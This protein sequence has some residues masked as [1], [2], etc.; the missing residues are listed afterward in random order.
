MPQTTKLFRIFGIQIQIHYSWWFIF[1]LLTWSLSSAFFPSFFPDY[2][3]K[4]YWFMGA[5]SSLLLFVSVLFHELS[6]SLVARLRK[7]K[8]E[9]IT[10]FF[11][12]GVAGI[13]TEDIK[14]MSEFLMA[15]SGP[16]FSLVL[17]G[18]FY[19]IYL[20]NFNGVSTA[21]TF[22]LAQ[23]NLILALFN[24]VPGF[25]LDG[26]RAFRAI[27]YAYYKD[28][29]KA[30]RIASTGGKI[31]GAFF[32]ILGLVSL[33][34]GAG[35]G[36]WFVLIGGFLYFIAGVSYNQVV[37]KQVLEKI[38]VKDLMAKN[39][40]L[41]DPEMKLS[42]FIKQYQNSGREVFLVK[43]DKFMGV[44]DLKNLSS[45]ISNK[46]KLKQVVSKFDVKNSLRLQ[47]NAYTAFKELLEKKVDLLPVMKDKE[48]AGVISHPVV[49][50]R[51]MWE[52]RF[53]EGRVE[54]RVKKLSRKLY[55][56]R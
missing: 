30:T 33:F 43:N 17:S 18:I 10:L 29:R 50:N 14:P 16:L 48:F 52:L 32:I 21:I 12:G 34:S 8:V 39:F 54:G 20:S 5:V 49:M 19:S 6:H 11:F 23:I 28:L 42:D 55:N 4:T 45:V 26:G 56:R 35:T 47:D 46:L 27:L 22:Y 37:I 38:S 44:F 2:D 53:N 1:G 3:V 24:L 9:S 13:T 15:V 41:V 25:P 7:I 51:L 31:F 40:P 36:L